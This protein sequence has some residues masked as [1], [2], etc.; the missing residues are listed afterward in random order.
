MRYCAD[1]KRV[2]SGDENAKH[3]WKNRIKEAKE[4]LFETVSRLKSNE[5]ESKELEE[6]LASEVLQLR[7]C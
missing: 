2:V 7:T 3:R 6:R 1:A 5:K 4:K